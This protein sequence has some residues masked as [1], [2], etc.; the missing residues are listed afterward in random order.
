MARSQSKTLIDSLKTC[1]CPRNRAKTIPLDGTDQYPHGFLCCLNENTF[2]YRLCFLVL[3][4]SVLL[5]SGTSPKFS[6]ESYWDILDLL[7]D[8][9]FLSFFTM[10]TLVQV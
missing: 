5:L 4:C 2:V 10:V 8:L 9:W 3:F 1:I 6:W 7:L